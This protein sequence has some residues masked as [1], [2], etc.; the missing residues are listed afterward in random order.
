LTGDHSSDDLYIEIA[1][2]NVKDVNVKNV[3]KYNKRIEEQK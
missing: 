1:L 2:E 3:E